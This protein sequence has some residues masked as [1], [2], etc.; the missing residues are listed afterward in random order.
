MGGQLLGN[1]WRTK[2][3]DR[4]VTLVSATLEDGTPLLTVVCAADGTVRVEQHLGDA[5]TV[6][7]TRDGPGGYQSEAKPVPAG[8]NAV[9]YL[10]GAQ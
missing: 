3:Q 6:R 10:T 7:V 5:V 4:E 9:A 1:S 2:P 8:Y